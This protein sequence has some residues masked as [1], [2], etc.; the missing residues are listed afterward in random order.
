V[1][2]QT[3]LAGAWTRRGPKNA[4]LGRLHAAR[5]VNGSLDP[6]ALCGFHLTEKALSLR[7]YPPFDETNRKAC[8]ICVVESWS[9]R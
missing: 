2:T 6:I 1:S 3:R 4:P 8:S 9:E 5:R 7:P